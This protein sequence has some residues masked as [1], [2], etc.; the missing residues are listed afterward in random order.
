MIELFQKASKMIR[1][2]RPFLLLSPPGVYPDT[3]HFRSAFELAAGL[4]TA[5]AGKR[6]LTATLSP[7]SPRASSDVRLS[8]GFSILNRI[9][10]VG[11]YMELEPFQVNYNDSSQTRSFRSGDSSSLAFGCGSFCLRK[12]P[13]FLAFSTVCSRKSTVLNSIGRSWN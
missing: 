12:R 13:S 8:H 5:Q 1:L 7:G 9:H 2:E 6:C 3:P 11:H 4:R 10:G